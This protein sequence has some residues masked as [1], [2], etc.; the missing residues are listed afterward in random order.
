M[1]LFAEDI[2]DKVSVSEVTDKLTFK[3][4]GFE[5]NAPANVHSVNLVAY[6]FGPVQVDIEHYFEVEWE[7]FAKEL[8]PWVSLSDASCPSGP[9]VIA[10]VAVVAGRQVFEL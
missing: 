6:M 9:A 3:E 5:D 4:W 2:A 10:P 7:Y 8:L 1:A